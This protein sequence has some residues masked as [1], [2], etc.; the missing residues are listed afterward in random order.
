MRKAQRGTGGGGGARIA[1][2]AAATALALAAVGVGAHVT[3]VA[4]WLPTKGPL[5]DVF[6]KANRGSPTVTSVAVRESERTKNAESCDGIMISGA[7]RPSG[8]YFDQFD[9]TPTCV[10][11]KSTEREFEDCRDGFC[12]P[13][14]VFVP[15][16]S[17]RMGSPGNEEGSAADEGPQRI[18][19]IAK[20]FAVGKFEV[21][22]AEWDACVAGGGCQSNKTPSDLGWGKGL[23][24]VINVSW[25][26]AKAYVGWLSKTTGQT[27]RLLTESEWEYAARAGTTTLFSTGPTIT[28]KQAN[29]DG[30]STYG[31]SA[32]GE[33]HGK[34]VE[35][36]SFAPNAFGLH[37]MHGNVWEWVEDCWIDSYKGAPTDASARTTA[38]TDDKLR[39]LRGGSWF[40]VPEVL[41][42]ADRIRNSADNRG[43]KFGFR[44]ARSVL[45]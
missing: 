25:E 26:D 11:S 24:P 35:V 39:V 17:F 18:V 4:P 1:G 16:G 45:R 27:Y 42:S 40:N 28:T 9:K 22:F 13:Q 15:V 44:V 2:L 29:F 19:T 10:T 23:R 7:K 8:N 32:K 5:D 20:P 3:G 12:G 33:Y 6:E 30:N 37:E 34:T 43:Y 36:G 21:T 14:M 41:R 38:C 31:G